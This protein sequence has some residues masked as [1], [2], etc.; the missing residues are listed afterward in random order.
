MSKQK[1][2]LQKR[3]RKNRTHNT[4]LEQNHFSLTLQAGTR[5]WWWSIYTQS[6][7][8]YMYI[9]AKR[10]FPRIT[11]KCT[12]WV[13]G[14]VCGLTFA[15][16][17]EICAHMRFLFC[18]CMEAF[19]PVNLV[20]LSVCGACFKRLSSFSFVSD[21][22]FY[23]KYI[24]GKCWVPILPLGENMCGSTRKRPFMWRCW[25]LKERGEWVKGAF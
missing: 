24:I 6:K 25:S 19:V 11:V 14:C 1:Y 3:Y 20:R 9:D 4:M 18:L 16:C 21:M 2:N 15:E 13:C 22:F 5:T 12:Q 7:I 10:L 17:N 8:L 23:G